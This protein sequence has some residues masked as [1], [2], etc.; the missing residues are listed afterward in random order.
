MNPRG[1]ITNIGLSSISMLHERTAGRA[2]VMAP[3]RSSLLV[4]GQ[5]PN[6]L[7]R[8]RFHWTPGGGLD[9][10]ES[11]EEGTR[12]E[13]VEEVGLRIDALGPLVL[14]RVGEFDFG[15]R[16]IRQTESFF[17]VAVPERFTVV[18]EKLSPLEAEAILDFVWLTPDE[19]RATQHTVYPRRLADLVDH[20]A[21]H[22][23]PA[24]PW[25]DDRE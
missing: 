3:D 23:P 19:M 16:R 2:I 21:A 1:T 10:G 18:P 25:T 8:G 14:R 7:G 17:L 13:L 15:G 20:I 24:T 11:P 4:L 22:G 5:D 12:R 6:D 9:G